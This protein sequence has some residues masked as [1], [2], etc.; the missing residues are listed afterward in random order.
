MYAIRSYYVLITSLLGLILLRRYIRDRFFDKKDE[1]TEDQLEEFIGHKALALEDFVSGGGKVEFKG[2]QWQAESEDKV[3]KGDN[4][5]IV[6]KES[7]K[8]IV[9]LK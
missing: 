6:A 5:V 9:K 3:S 1:K 4:V 7:L 8:L 2:T